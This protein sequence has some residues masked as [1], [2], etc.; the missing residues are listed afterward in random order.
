MNVSWSVPPEVRDAPNLHERKDMGRQAA[1]LLL[2]L[3]EYATA[4]SSTKV[5]HRLEFC[6]VVAL[7]V[8]GHVEPGHCFKVNGRCM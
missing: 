6:N 4:H 7:N 8:S 2:E 5:L 1:K 3:S